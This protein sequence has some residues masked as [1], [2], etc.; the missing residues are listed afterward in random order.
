MLGRIANLSEYQEFE[1]QLNLQITNLHGTMRLPH[2]GILRRVPYEKLYVEPAVSFI[3][4][5]KGASSFQR[6][7]LTIQALA[8]Q[9]SRIV[10][11]GDPGG[12]KSRY[13]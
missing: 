3:E 7:T 13:L 6:R 1:K 11:L 5:P 12:G 2:A 8:S 10:L 4:N 9:A